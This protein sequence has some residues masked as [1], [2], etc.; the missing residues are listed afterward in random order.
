VGGAGGEHR[1]RIYTVGHSTRSS[2]ELIALLAAHG[3][4]R[5][6][7]V[8]RYPGSRRFPHFSRDA[9]ARTLEAN[10]IEY[11]HAP[12]LGG[13]RAPLPDSVNTAWR[14]A[15]FRGYADHM[16]S[17]EFRRW[18]ERLIAWAPGADTTVMC[19]EAVPWRCHRQLIADALVARGVQVLDIFGASEAKNH[20]LSAHARV[21][22]DGSVTYPSESA[23]PDAQES[24]FEE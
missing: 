17:E 10:R 9:L 11:L 5:L 14:A 21:A 20:E 19:A 16:A 2:E 23:S 12:E 8:R 13:R 15:A 22:A 18:L 24:L 4:R 6:V 7:D 1:G 3:V